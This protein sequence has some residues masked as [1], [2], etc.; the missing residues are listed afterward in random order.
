MSNTILLAYATKYGSTREIAEAMVKALEGKKVKVD[1]QLASQ[2]STLEGYQA[3]VLGAP[4][5]MFKWHKDARRFLKKHKKMLAQM[6]VAIFAV[7]PSFKG[8]EEEFK[9]SWEQFDKALTDFPWLEPS[10]KEVFGGKFDPADLSF[11]FSTTL[12][13]IP[14]A[15][16]RDW[17]A[18][19]KWAEG[20]VKVLG[21]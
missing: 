14:A 21:K 12:K 5:F 9:G 4:L 8:D 20:L 7:G 18:I 17:D 15:D 10:A 6:P 1:L 13:D 16:L 3:V 2:V 19:A 11:P